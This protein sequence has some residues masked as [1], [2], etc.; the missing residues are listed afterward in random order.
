MGQIKNI[1]L[2]I[3]TDIKIRKSKASH[4]IATLLP[5]G[6]LPEETNRW[7]CTQQ[8]PPLSHEQR[9]PR[10]EDR[11]IRQRH[12]QARGVRIPSRQTHCSHLAEV[13][14]LCWIL[15]HGDCFHPLLLPGEGALL[16]RT[17]GVHS[18]PTH[19]P[20]SLWWMA[21]AG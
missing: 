8:L 1:K 7:R 16:P 12:D 19:T 13:L 15:H 10:L 20:S 6:T 18:L 2:H 21:V 3:V 11:Q 14:T 5:S 9:E 17:S 4:G